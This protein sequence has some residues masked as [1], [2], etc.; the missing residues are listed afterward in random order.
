MSTVVSKNINIFIPIDDSI[1]GG[2]L[3]NFGAIKKNIVLRSKSNKRNSIK[4]HIID[5]VVI[6]DNISELQSNDILVGFIYQIIDLK[7]NINQIDSNYFNNF[8][9]KDNYF[10]GFVQNNSYKSKSTRVI[11]R[12][13]SNFS[14]KSTEGFVNKKLTFSKL[15]HLVSKTI[16]MNGNA[17]YYPNAGNINTI[18]SYFISRNCGINDGLYQIDSSNGKFILEQNSINFEVLNIA[19]NLSKDQRY[20][21]GIFFMTLNL[22]KSSQKYGYRALRFSLISVGCLVQQLSLVSNS[23]GIKFRVIGGFDDIF[24]KEYLKIKEDNIVIAFLVGG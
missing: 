13:D 19:F 4:F 20:Y 10:S 6:L 18:N 11:K 9:I 2:Y 7:L 16:K 15:N 5:R 24:L 14:Y 17:F 23:I 12:K 1:S 3:G 21:S 8:F 22:G